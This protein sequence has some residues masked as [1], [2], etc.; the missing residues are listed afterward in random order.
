MKE[1]QPGDMFNKY[2][3]KK[4]ARKIEVDPLISKINA[5]DVEIAALTKKKRTAVMGL[6]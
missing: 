3:A 4:K 2:Q 5:Q 6:V 1:L